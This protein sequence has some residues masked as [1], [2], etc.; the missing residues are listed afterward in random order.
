M[1]QKNQ[2]RF[3]T[4]VK[5]CPM[6]GNQTQPLISIIINCY[7]G[8]RYLKQAFDSVYAQTYQNWEIIFWDNCST[9]ESA[10]IVK[11]YD[12][13]IKYYCGDKNIKL[14]A[15]RNKALE[16]C[17]GEYIAFLDCDDL[18]LPRK[19]ELQV[20]AALKHNAAM[21]YSSYDYIDAIDN[22]SIGHKVKKSKGHLLSKNIRRY[23]V[24]ILTALVRKSVIMDNNLRFDDQ[25]NFCGD[26]LLFF[27]VLARGVAVSLSSKLAVYRKHLQ[28]LSHKM[29]TLEILKE[30]RYMLKKL[31]QDKI[32]AR[33]TQRQWRQFKINMMYGVVLVPL[34]KRFKFSTIRKLFISKLQLRIFF[35]LLIP[36]DRIKSYIVN[37][38]LIDS[39]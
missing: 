26:S 34:L 24:G 14:Y 19:L 5:N 37:R 7:N 28:S 15:A 35:L 13:K 32:F 33:L 39:H 10:D 25:L 12:R 9:D 17:T 21:V 11:C 36:S 29:H 23:E 38:V 1:T 2:K 8:A 27:Q 4:A 20:N 31:K 30:Q 18:W 6:S 16:Q 22:I 3:T